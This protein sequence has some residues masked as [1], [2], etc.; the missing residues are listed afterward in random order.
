VIQERK[1]TEER[2]GNKEEK[3]YETTL[4]LMHVSTMTNHLVAFVLL[5]HYFQ[6]YFSLF[7]IIPFG[8][9]ESLWG[10]EIPG[11]R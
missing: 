7:H 4:T 11:I 10:V 5:L 9:V 6:T 2:K 8:H 1:K 3:G